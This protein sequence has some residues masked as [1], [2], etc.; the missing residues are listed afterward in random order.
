MLTKIFTIIFFITVSH[1]NA[2]YSS[3]KVMPIHKAY[4]DSIK[5]IKYD[6]VFPIWGQGAYS[7]GFDI[8]Y[9]VGIMANYF[10]AKQ[11][12]I[13][14]NLQL[15]FQN[16]NQ[17]FELQPVDFIEFGD[18]YSTTETLMIRPDLWVLPFLN[19]YGLFGVGRSKTEVN[20]DKIGNQTLGLKSVVDQSVKTA[21]FGI[22]AAGGLG[23]VWIAYDAN[24][25][26]TKPELLDKSVK[27]VTSGI[28]FG[29]NFVYASKPY[30]N[31]GLWIGAMSVKMGSET[32]GELKLS[33]ALP[34]EVWDKKDEIVTNYYDW[35]D[36]EAS[37][38]QK[39][40]ADKTIGPIID[41]IGAAEGDGIIKYGLDKSVKQRWNGLVG[42]QY[43]HNK[44]WMLRSEVGFIGD[45]KSLLI[46]LNYRFN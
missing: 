27:V 43:Q 9:P 44:N 10:Y 21:G 13:I 33:D 29:H 14:D 4:T 19:V 46:S 6:K 41:A 45:R 8:P 11:R 1:A 17:D 30:R 38:P 20:L 40:I 28:R 32:R 18:N 12:L 31:I 35:Y 7:K 2:Q 36:N 39:V 5:A 16:E 34:S 42:G 37:L 23:P 26:W 3:K 25:S 24:V 22:T 15:G